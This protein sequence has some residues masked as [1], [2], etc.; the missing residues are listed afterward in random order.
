MNKKR[1]LVDIGNSR[2]KWCWARPDGLSLPKMFDYHISSWD[3]LFLNWLDEGLS[4]STQVFYASVCSDQFNQ[5]FENKLHACIQPLLTRIK[6]TDSFS[7]IINGYS[8]PSKLGVDRWL[9]IIAAYKLFG[10]GALVIDAGTALTLDFID[11]YGVHQG[12]VIV[13]GLVMAKNTLLN[14]TS[15]QTDASQIT[16]P[17]LLAKNTEDAINTGV[18]LML[19]ALIKQY[20]SAL[21]STYPEFKCLIT[22]GDAPHLKRLLDASWKLQ[23]DLVLQGLGYVSQTD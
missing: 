18:E 16:D 11:Q 4:N 12:G 17:V 20:K 22:G 5:Q 13:P 23:D 19:V 21:I 2:I 8:Q 14:S 3:Q 15:I 1:L 7:G 10:K 6:T 9:A